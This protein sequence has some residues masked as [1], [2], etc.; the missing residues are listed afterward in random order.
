MRNA[1]L[2]ALAFVVVIAAVVY[3][4]VARPESSV[5]PTP[6]PTPA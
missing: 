4:A 5:I 2:A 6:A 3:V 1:A